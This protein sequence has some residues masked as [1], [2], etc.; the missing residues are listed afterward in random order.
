MKQL[1]LWLWCFPQNLVGFMVKHI[2][3]AE[4][5]G[6][7]YRFHSKLG[8][9]S[10]GEYIFLCP[11][12]WRDITTLKHEHGHRVQSRILGWLYLPI[13]ALPSIIWAGYFDWY[14]EKYN[15]SYYSFYTEKWADQIA[16]IERNQYNDHL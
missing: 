16:G 4:K 15:V 1:L 12:H 3:K 5:K 11:D 7:H 10:L 13:I 2:T 6:N 9:V 8:S 14:R